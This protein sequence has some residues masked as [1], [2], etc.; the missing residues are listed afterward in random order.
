MELFLASRLRGSSVM[1]R[2]PPASSPPPPQDD[3]ARG[4]EARPLRW[5]NSVDEQLPPPVNYVARC[6]PARDVDLRWASAPDKWVLTV[7]HSHR[8][9]VLR[10]SVCACMR[11]G[12]LRRLS[13]GC[14]L[15]P[16]G[17]CAAGP[18]A[19]AGKQGPAAAWRAGTLDAYRQSGRQ[20]RR[21]GR[22]SDC[23]V[24]PQLF[25]SP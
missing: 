9:H 8:S 5:E 17:P 1:N 20:S 10:R 18:A 11:G 6:V 21:V 19:A 4:E 22:H 14:L 3:Y 2:P 25:R 13:D 16:A 23:T 12:L 24:S 15:W 7:A